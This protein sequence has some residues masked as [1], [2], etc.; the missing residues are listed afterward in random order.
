M[1]ISK[2]IL[3]A[4]LAAAALSLTAAQARGPGIILYQEDRFGGDSRAISEDQPD[5]DWIHFD[6]R[7]SSV[8]VRHGVWELCEHSH[9]RGRC[10]TIDHDVGKLSRIGFDDRASS[11]RRI[12]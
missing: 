6:D 10:V 1:R 4:G 7:V 9:Y 12:R 5:L 8:E 2:T 3:L 11:V